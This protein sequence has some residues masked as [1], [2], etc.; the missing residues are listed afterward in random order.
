M[1]A[2]LSAL[3]EACTTNRL[4]AKVLVTPSRQAGLQAAEALALQAVPWINLRVMTP[5]DIAAQVLAANKKAADDFQAGKEQSLTF[6]VG[7]V[8]RISKG[9]AN[10]KTV[11]DLIKKKV[12]EK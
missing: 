8:M 3:A 11:G 10:P 12:E 7:Q 9:R 2:F 6:L 4:G 5:E 1:N